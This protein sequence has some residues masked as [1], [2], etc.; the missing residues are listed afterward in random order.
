[1]PPGS[2]TPALRCRFVSLCDDGDRRLRRYLLCLVAFRSPR[3]VGD[4][5]IELRTTTD[6]DADRIAGA[7]RRDH[8]ATADPAVGL[9]PRADPA[10][11]R[12]TPSGTGE[13]HRAQGS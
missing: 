3:A 9:L 1:M 7:D 4:T 11:P 8:G 2:A 10:L 5:A 6:G 13:A 12:R